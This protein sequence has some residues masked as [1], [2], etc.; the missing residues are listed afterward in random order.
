[1]FFKPIQIMYFVEGK[2]QAA[3]TAIKSLVPTYCDEEVN[4]GLCGITILYD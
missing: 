3:L 4:T 1:M 2:K